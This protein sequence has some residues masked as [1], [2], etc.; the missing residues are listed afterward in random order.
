MDLAG[1]LC[2]FFP[3]FEAYTCTLILFKS[4]FNNLVKLVFSYSCPDH[5]LSV[6]QGD[7]LEF[8]AVSLINNWEQ[9]N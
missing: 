7:S 5:S 4:Y 6:L 9:S 8:S 2:V 3:C 1:V